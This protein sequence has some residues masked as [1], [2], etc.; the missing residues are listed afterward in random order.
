MMH[1]KHALA[2]FFASMLL[3]P[4]L[5]GA[6]AERTIKLSDLR[7]RIEAAWAGKMIGVAIGA[8]T[9]FRFQGEIVPKEKIV[10]RPEMIREALR[11]DDLYIQLTM[12][13]AL[14]E[15]GLGATTEDFGRHFAASQF[16]LW[17]AHMASRRLMRRG[18]P[19]AEAGSPKFNAHYNDISFQIDADFF[20]LMC[21]GMPNTANG[22]AKRAGVMI[23]WGDD[24][25]GAA[26]ISGMYAAAYFAEP[27]D[28]RKV[29]EAGLRSAP[30]DSDYAAVLR[31]VLAMHAE[32]P[33]DWQSAWRRI[34]AKWDNQDRCPFGVLVP[35]NIDAKLN[36]GYVAIGLL[37]GNGDFA[38]TLDIATAC[39]QDSD[40]NPSTAA[41]VLG[42]MHGM[43]GIPA[44]YVEQL[45]TIRREPFE[46]T[47]TSY[48]TI[49]E[50][51][52]TR[53]IEL[54]KANGGSVDGEGVHVAE[55][56][57]TPIEM[58]KFDPIGV[59][60]ERIHCVDPRW[61]WSGKWEDATTKK[62]GAEKIA[63]E[64]GAAASIEFE[65]TGVMIVGP[66]LPNGGKADVFLDGHLDKTVDVNC[67]ESKR[68]DNENVYHN[69]YLPAGKHTV[70]LV[71]SGEP[72][73]D[74]KGTELRII[75][76][77][78]FR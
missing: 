4:G 46:N 76:L 33:T 40:C 63:S 13:E 74:A 59:P 42:A 60:V 55:Q 77:V 15:K 21:P 14:D 31:D 48:D 69:F 32:N 12:A 2:A 44:T 20:G 41:G 16:R 37:Y 22:F 57:P 6:A 56:T 18:V 19:A 54:V 1:R 29:V 10:W 30:A 38:K 58:P 61:T 62:S 28:V 17:H 8:P 7:D 78:V 25:A 75:D 50:H 51:T 52:F 11:Q 23:G 34:N 43:R 39:G 65:G 68:K 3:V 24:I 36:G 53:A 9:E 26:F 5:S 72:F 71:V 64:K 47:H 66:Y 67:D 35:L 70:K 49:V 27:G 45:P 73:G